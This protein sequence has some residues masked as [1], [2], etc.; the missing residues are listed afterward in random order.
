MSRVLHQHL[1]KTI[2][3]VQSPIKANCNPPRWRDRRSCM[4]EH[5]GESWSTRSGGFDHSSDTS[6][7]DSLP[8][9]PGCQML[10]VFNQ[11][12]GKRYTWT[13]V[14]IRSISPILRTFLADLA[15]CVANSAEDIP[16]VSTVF[17]VSV[18][19]VSIA[20]LSP[21]I[22][23]R[24][25]SLKLSAFHAFARNCTDGRPGSRRVSVQTHK[26][27]VLAYKLRTGCLM[28]MGPTL[29]NEPT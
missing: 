4:W 13:P 1:L 11:P 24:N 27:H 3:E 21:N 17:D 10:L 26:A 18:W 7:L 22:L 12:C 15:V 28:H 2:T 29:F 25:Q 6:V 8:R 9:H 19:K 5:R 14:D 16:S 23:I 20:W